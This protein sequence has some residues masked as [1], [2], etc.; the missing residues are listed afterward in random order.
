MVKLTFGVRPKATPL[1]MRPLALHIVP[2]ADVLWTSGRFSGTFLG[3]PRDV[4]L[5]NGWSQFETEIDCADITTVSKFSYLQE[6]DIPKVRLLIDGLPFNTEGYERAKTIQKSKFGKVTCEV[7][8]THI[9][10][11]VSLHSNYAK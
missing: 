8:N 9:Q 4:I 1:R 6:L 11:I 7:T 2:Y 5:P 10:C 3:R